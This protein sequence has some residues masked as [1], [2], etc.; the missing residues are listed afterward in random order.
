[1]QAFC[2]GIYA[3]SE[4]LV[5]AT[6]DLDRGRTT[7]EAVDEAFERDLG[8]LVRVQQEAGLEPLADGMLRWQDLWRPLADA[9]DGLEA[10]P[11]VRFLDTNTF[12]R[13][14]LVEGEPRLRD[15]LPPPDVG[16]APWLATLP[17]PYSF[18]VAA[19]GDVPAATLA[20]NVLA[21][22]LEAWADAGCALVVLDEPFLAGRPDG[23]GELEDALALLPHAVPL[24]LRL[25]FADAGAL[26]P[27]L[28]DL[29]VDGIGVDF[30]ATS[31]EDVPAE[32]PRMLLAGVVD[33]RGSAL[34]EPDGIRRFVDALRERTAG[35]VAL[36]PNGDLQFVPEAIARRKL[37]VLGRAAAALREQAVPSS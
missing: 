19:N 21:P 8:E 31:L 20:Q 10:R 18:S 35:D 22:Q 15:P 14:P 37:A 32:F 36:V 9:S 12:Y 1:V 26:L 3:R 34:E 13:A 28:A 17:S 30:Y 4:E 25:P 24:H 6:R 2:P 23:L 5:Q 33:A 27:R 29:P 16:D 7:P 11:L